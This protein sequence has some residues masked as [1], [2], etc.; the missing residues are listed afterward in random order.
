MDG[1]GY[2][3]R[4]LMEIHRFLVKN[5]LK[6]RKYILLRDLVQSSSALSLKDVAKWS[7]LKIPTVRKYIPLLKDFE[8][9][10]LSR[11]HG[12]L[13]MTFAT[14]SEAAICRK[15]ET[16]LMAYVRLKPLLEELREDLERYYNQK[17]HQIYAYPVETMTDIKR[18]WR[19]VLTPIIYKKKPKKQRD[20]YQTYRHASRII[21][22]VQDL[23]L[24]E[25]GIPRAYAETIMEAEPDEE[26]TDADFSD[27]WYT[28]DLKEDARWK[29]GGD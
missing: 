14:A 28:E 22:T 18:R 6:W 3:A 29:E 8:E 26:E 21:N 23:V 7:D 5:G 19:E 2:D 15:R 13:W 9:I 12:T 1:C 17:H 10:H 25:M 20:H 4:E 27:W 11:F 24:R 16:S